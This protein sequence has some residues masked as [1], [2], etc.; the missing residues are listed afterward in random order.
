MIDTG[1][2]NVLARSGNIFVAGTKVV[3]MKIPTANL[4]FVI[5]E[6][7]KK[8]YPGNCDNDRQL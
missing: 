4:G 8:V 1:N 6:S 2:D 7:L 3:R 5:M